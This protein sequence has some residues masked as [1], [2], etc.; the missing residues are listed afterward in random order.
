MCGGISSFIFSTIALPA[1]GAGAMGLA[2][3]EHRPVRCWPE[4]LHLH[5]IRRRV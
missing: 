5:K 4:D 3:G 1:F 2:W